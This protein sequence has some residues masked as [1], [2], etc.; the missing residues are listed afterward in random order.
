MD[1]RQLD[2]VTTLVNVLINDVMTT[3]ILQHEINWWVRSNV[4]KELP[5]TAVEHVERMICEGYSSGE[6]CVSWV[7]TR[8]R[9]H[10]TTGWWNIKKCDC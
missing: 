3:E 6:L 1:A 10:E 8:N 4:I 2:K 7:D 5:Q 9:Y